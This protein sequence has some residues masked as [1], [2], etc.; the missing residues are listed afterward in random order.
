M[1][2][3]A[4]SLKALLPRDNILLL[5]EDQNKKRTFEQAAQLLETAGG[6]MKPPV[7]LQRNDLFRQFMQRERMGSTSIGF[8]GAI[9][10]VHMKDIKEPLCVL[11]RL[12]NPIQYDADNAP[13]SA[14]HTLFFV[15]AP[16]ENSALHLKLLA[17]F[18]HI[19]ADEAFMDELAKCTNP[20][21][22]H[23]EIIAWER[24]NRA[25]LDDIW[26]QG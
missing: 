18:S 25:T 26:A 16:E 21:A 14:V 3:A 19:L 6:R 20:Q 1:A 4:L 22:I 2:N 8:F 12:K 10:H 13:T 24:E 15:V 11:A 17:V 9:P 23:Q 7:Q 5:A